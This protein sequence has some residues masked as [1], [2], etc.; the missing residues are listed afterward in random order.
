MKDMLKKHSWIKVVGILVVLAIVGVFAYNMYQKSAAE[1]DA[2]KS[3]GE[4]DKAAGEVATKT[5]TQALVRTNLGPALVR[6]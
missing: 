3:T 1:A 2:K 5:E 4:P 6:Q